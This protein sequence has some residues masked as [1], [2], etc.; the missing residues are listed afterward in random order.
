MV[1]GNDWHLVDNAEQ[2]TALEDACVL[3]RKSVEI[4]FSLWNL[5]FGTKY[6]FSMCFWKIFLK[7]CYSG[8][9]QIFTKKIFSFE[10]IHLLFILTLRGSIWGGDT[11]CDRLLAKISFEYFLSISS[12]VLYFWKSLQFRENLFLSKSKCWFL[13]SIGSQDLRDQNSRCH[14]GIQLSKFLHLPIHCT[15]LVW[16]FCENQICWTLRGQY[17]SM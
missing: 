2:L 1:G 3:P 16:R 11:L 8:L 17:R 13:Q 5:V 15:A 4:V 6:T 10:D 9:L 7:V 12:S 14:L